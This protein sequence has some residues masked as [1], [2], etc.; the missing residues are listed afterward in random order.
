MS[1]QNET[2]WPEDD[3]TIAYYLEELARLPVT[4]A[5]GRSPLLTEAARRLRQGR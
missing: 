3:A 5:K 1:E 2:E 4:K